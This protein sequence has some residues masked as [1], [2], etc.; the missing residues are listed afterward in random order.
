LRFI[1]IRSS[2]NPFE[3][4]LAVSGLNEIGEGCCGGLRESRGGSEQNEN[5]RAQKMFHRF[6]TLALTIEC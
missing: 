1:H 3:R 5:Y 2:A 4:C 6:S